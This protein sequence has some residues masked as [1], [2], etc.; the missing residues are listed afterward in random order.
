MMKTG[1]F[2]DSYKPGNDFATAVALLDVLL[3][4]KRALRPV[5]SIKR[6]CEQTDSW[7]ELAES[8]LGRLAQIGYVSEVRSSGRRSAWVLIADP[9]AATLKPVFEAF[10][11]DPSIKLL[12][13]KSAVRHPWSGLL[14]QSQ[15]LGLPLEAVLRGPGAG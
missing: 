11:L 14:L 4:E 6:L 13:K 15:A 5:V 1:R 12:G 10:V 9:A 2:A 7:P 8:A 3:Q